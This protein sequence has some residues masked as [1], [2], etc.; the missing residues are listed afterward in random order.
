MD[1]ERDLV[2]REA[3]LRRAVEQALSEAKEPLI[4]MQAGPGS[5]PSL[6]GVRPA[7]PAEQLRRS[8]PD[9]AAFRRAT[10]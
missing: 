5:V 1:A 8:G 10:Q 6:E 3:W 9:V 2:P 7:A 4:P